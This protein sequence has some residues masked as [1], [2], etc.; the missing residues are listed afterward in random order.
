[1][2][3]EDKMKWYQD[4]KGN[5]S[6]LRILALPAGFVGMAITIAGVVAMFMDKSTAGT[7]MSIGLAMLGMALG[8]K[9]GQKFA[10]AK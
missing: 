8:G 9:V 5:I 2:V 7:A 10:E 6:T 1:M 4:D 3:L